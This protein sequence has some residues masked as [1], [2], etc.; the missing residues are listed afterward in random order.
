MLL[1]DH[2]L[3]QAVDP[4][5]ARA[6]LQKHLPMALEGLRYEYDGDRTI[7]LWLNAKKRTG[8]TD[9]Y[10]IR[11][12]F[13]YYPNWPP[14]VTFLNP[15]TREYDGSHWPSVAGSSRIA[16]HPRYGDAP[17]GMVCNSMTFEYYFWGGHSAAADIHWDKNIHTFAATVAELIDH[18]NSPFYQGK[19]T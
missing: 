7:Y 13:L 16:F 9:E 3:P 6:A 4:F 2:D 11:L 12:L 10:L 15:E 17:S 1:P 8:D 5:T 19:Q 14:S 18:L